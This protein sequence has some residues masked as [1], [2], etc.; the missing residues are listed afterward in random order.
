MNSNYSNHSRAASARGFLARCA[1][2]ALAALGI[3]ADFRRWQCSDS[4]LYG[5]ERL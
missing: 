5:R 2:T 4:E 1:I 3:W